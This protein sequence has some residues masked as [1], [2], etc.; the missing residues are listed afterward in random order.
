MV[1]RERERDEGN[2]LQQDV[3]RAVVDLAHMLTSVK[4]KHSIGSSYT[5]VAKAR[6][7]GFSFFFR[8]IFTASVEEKCK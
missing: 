3:L 1:A 7:D 2:V 6:N 8:T 5:G 4:L